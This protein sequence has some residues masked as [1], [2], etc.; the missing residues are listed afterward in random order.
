MKSNGSLFIYKC[1]I[2]Q[3]HFVLNLIKFLVGYPFCMRTLVR[4]IS[5]YV[6]LINFTYELLKSH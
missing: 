6:S 3:F 2:K 4:V 1:L 5:V